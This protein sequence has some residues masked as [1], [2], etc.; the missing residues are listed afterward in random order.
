MIDD[1]FFM[2]FIKVMCKVKDL[3]FAA[4]FIISI[5]E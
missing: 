4:F 5:P 3:L 1:G 2:W